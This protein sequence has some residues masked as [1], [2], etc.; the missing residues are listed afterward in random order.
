ME[1]HREIYKTLS[2]KENRFN[3]YSILKSGKEL[4]QISKFYGQYMLIDYKD[5]SGNTNSEKL[6]LDEIAQETEGKNTP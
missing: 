5:A 3:F 2:T 6:V 4:K 1:L